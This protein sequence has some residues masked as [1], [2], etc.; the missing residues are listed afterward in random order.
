MEE[1]GLIWNTEFLLV[2]GIILLVLGGIMLLTGYRSGLGVTML[3]LYWVPVTFIVHDFWNIPKD[4]I[5][6]VECLK[7][8]DEYR[9]IEGI[10]FMKILPFLEAY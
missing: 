1:Y 6:S 3:I 9:R 7:W 10:M 5:Y 8:A 2:C 4:C